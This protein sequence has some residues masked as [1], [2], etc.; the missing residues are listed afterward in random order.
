[1]R[2][3][4][5]FFLSLFGCQTPIPTQPLPFPIKLE[6]PALPSYP[7]FFDQM[8]IGCNQFPKFAMLTCLYPK[9]NVPFPYCEIKDEYALHGVIPIAICKSDVDILK[10]HLTYARSKY[11]PSTIGL[12]QRS[13]DKIQS[14][15]SNTFTRYLVF[16]KGLEGQNAWD[17]VQSI[18][19]EYRIAGKFSE[20]MKEII[21]E[22]AAREPSCL[23][24]QFMKDLAAGNFEN[25]IRLSL[26][27][28]AICVYHK[29][30]D[31]DAIKIER[32]YVQSLI[33]KAA[34]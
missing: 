19:L 13:I 14:H 16:T 8:D 20:P 22:Q 9:Q 28:E 25:S 5:P 23:F 30:F 27:S 29:K 24:F 31:Y 7:E 6:M 33:R 3:C 11:R 34:K 1:M 26:D 12:M 4:I 18:Y 17:M 32:Y 21:S 15:D 10:S 2:L